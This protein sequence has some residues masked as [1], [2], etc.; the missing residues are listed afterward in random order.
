M[1][2]ARLLQPSRL[3]TGRLGHLAYALDGDIFVADWDGTGAVRIADGSPG[4]G[5]PKYLY[6]AW[7]PDGQHLAYRSW[8]DP[9]PDRGVFI[10]DV[11]G[12]DVVSF[13][14]GG[15]DVAWSP[16]STR[17]A[18]WVSERTVGVYGLDGKREALLPLPRGF[19]VYRDGD[20]TWSRDGAVLIS[21]RPDPGGDPRQTWELPL[22][23]GAP[24]VLPG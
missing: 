12:R 23:S 17:V 18:T 20:P 7:S 1:I 21:L 15:W 24:R 5:M 13:P 3:A 14:G 10:T 8:D 19:G 6:P 16:D 2:G 4:D 22:D 9:S 11:S